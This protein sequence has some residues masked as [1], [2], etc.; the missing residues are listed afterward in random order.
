MSKQTNKKKKKSDRI[1]PICLLPW[2]M[3]CCVQLANIGPEIFL[4]SVQLRLLLKEQPSDYPG[5]HQGEGQKTPEEP[6]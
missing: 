5:T 2:S 6:I 3:D 4:A 1:K